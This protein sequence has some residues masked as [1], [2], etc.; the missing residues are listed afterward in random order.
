MRSIRLRHCPRSTPDSSIPGFISPTLT[1]PFSAG[2][3][4]AFPTKA[5][6]Q[7]VTD[8]YFRGYDNKFPDFYRVRE[9]AREFDQF[10]LDRQL[11]NLEFVRVMHDHTGNVSTA[12]AGLNTPT[13]Q[14]ADNDYAVGLIVDKVSHSPRYKDNTL[15]FVVEDDSQDGPDHVD[16]HRSIAF[17]AGASVKRGVVVSRAYTTVNLVRTIVDVLGIPHFNINE[18]SA[19]PMAAVF[20]R[21]A[22]PWTFTAIVPGVLPIDPTGNVGLPLPPS[23]VERRQESNDLMAAV[24]RPQHDAA[25]WDERTRGLDFTAE[26]RVDAAAYNQILWR[27]IMG[28][29][30]PYPTTRSGANLRKDRK[31]LLKAYQRSLRH[32]RAAARTTSGQ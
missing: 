21:N 17:V 27:G 23:F 3:K 24:V 29:D 9:W 2:V 11:P 19:E 13:I 18:A 4:V 16:A 5:A 15:I 7:P 28:D 25:Y 12:T 8:Q 32:R 26:D 30:V 1:D 20:Q 31:A 22:K 10:E 6:L 14:T